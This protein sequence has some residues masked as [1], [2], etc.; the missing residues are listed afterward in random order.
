MK[1]LI[2]ALVC[3][4]I[5]SLLIQSCDFNDQ[6]IIYEEKLVVFASIVANM[7]VMDTV[8]VSRSANL[9]E[10]IVANELWID[11]ADVRLIHDSSSAELV[12]H[13]VGNGRYFPI[14]PGAGMEEITE[15][16]D[17]I[18]QPGDTYRLV[19][20]HDQDSVIAATDVPVSFDISP[21]DMGTYTC[22]D[23]EILPV[24]DVDVNN[25]DELS[26]EELVQLYQD[27]EGFVAANNI[28]VDS[29]IFRFGDC[30]TK[31]FA[32]Y[33]MFGIDFNDD[34]YNTIQ[35]ISLALEANT[36]GFEPQLDINNDG[37]IDENE[38]S[39]RNRNGIRDSCYIN[40][41]YNEQ[42]T[43]YFDN[44]SLSYNDIARI[45]KN[46]LRRE[47]QKGTWRENSPYRY[48]PWLWNIESAPT[49]VMWLYFDYY[50]YYLMT[51]NAT[52]ES[53]FNYFSGDPV[54][55]NIYLLPDTNLEGG[56]GVFYSS[57]ATSFL[58]YVQKDE[59]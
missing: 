23:G 28:N 31:S 21:A 40:L 47:T 59:D 9:G 53:Y 55:Q 58:V 7:S 46:P 34:D 1:K 38:F 36:V 54:G 6:E 44:D 10:D 12:F 48:N 17:F 13:S 45:W 37:N 51:F 29:I 3:L 5:I 15:Y 2:Q 19:V 42:K 25:L 43:K 32:S 14:R 26:L 24:G 11:D 57:A 22:P 30:F 50:G 41:I 20:V 49:V 16:L 33:P 35:I 27:P 8:F 18:I 56:L 39:D 4:G 52:S